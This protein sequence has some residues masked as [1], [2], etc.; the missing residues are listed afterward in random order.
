MKNSPRQDMQVL[1]RHLYGTS[2]MLK[3]MRQRIGSLADMLA[4]IQAKLDGLG[5]LVWL[6]Q[7]SLNF[8]RQAYWQMMR[9]VAPHSA[10]TQELSMTSAKPFSLYA[11]ES[12]RQAEALRDQYLALQAHTQVVSTGLAD[13]LGLLY[14]QAEPAMRMVREC[15][16]PPSGP[17]VGLDGLIWQEVTEMESSLSATRILMNNLRL[18]VLGLQAKITHDVA[19][20]ERHRH[21]VA[22]IAH[23]M[24]DIEYNSNILSGYT[25]GAVQ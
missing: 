23:A 21:L 9:W 12:L 11:A 8:S 16:S 2:S 24:C 17:Q 20:S 25:L 19:A 15:L 1:Q 10:L 4:N 3:E 18:Q 6:K 5:D 22:E 14:E 13:M 7:E